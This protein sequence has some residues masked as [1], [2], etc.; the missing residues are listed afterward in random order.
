MEHPLDDCRLK[1]ARAKEQFDALH[2]EIVQ[3]S[4]DKPY[5]VNIKVDPATGDEIFESSDPPKFPRR[6]GVI[7]GEIAHNSRS[8][9]DYLVSVLVKEA[10]REP[11][12]DNAFPIS[13][14]KDRYLRKNKRGVSYRDRLLKGVPGPL[15]AKIDDLQPYHRKKLAYA[16]CLMALAYLTNRDKHRELHPAYAWINT[17]TKA[18]ALPTDDEYRNLTIRLMREG[19]FDVQAEF[20]HSGGTPARIVIYPDV[21]VQR[22]TGVEVVFG[23]DPSHLHGMDD[24]YGL[25]GYVEAIVE[26]FSGDV[27]TGSVAAAA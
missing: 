5:V 17:P 12:G 9:L 20:M 13:K 2:G 18:F 15:K 1:I 27:G 16:D 19:G 4:K 7:V 23:T 22:P 6:W 8:A 14:T 11:N 3:F 26:S 24:L 25:V 10:G 21:K